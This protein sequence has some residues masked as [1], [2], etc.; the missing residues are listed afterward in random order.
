[1]SLPPSPL[2]VLER[3]HRVIGT[4][5]ARLMDLGERIRA[6]ERVSPG[7]VR[8][9]VGLLDAYLHRVHARQ[10][11]AELWPAA[12]S[13]APTGCHTALRTVVD[14]HT[15]MRQSAREILELTGRWAKGEASAQKLV[16]WKLI[17]LASAD[18]AANE[19]EEQHPFSCL[20][21]TLPPQAQERVYAQF[22]AHSGTKRALEANISRFLEASRDLPS[23][24]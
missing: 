1:M 2:N 6:D 19:F 5:L 22:V 9:G 21:T 17:G 24:A 23:E 20:A 16:A 3:E 15:R 14:N 10:F 4:L 13:V 11:D 12:V 18:H 7:T 8:L